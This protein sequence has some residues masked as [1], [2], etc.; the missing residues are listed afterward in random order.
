MSEVF[1]LSNAHLEIEERK[2]Y[3][4]ARVRGLLATAA[5]VGRTTTL[6]RDALNKMPERRLLIDAQQLDLPLPDP[7]C[8]AA[9]E[10]I[11]A[12]DYSMLACTLPHE[13]GDLT[14]TRM[15]MTGLSSGL[16]LRAFSNILDAHR[17]LDLRPSGIHRRPSSMLPI[18]TDPHQSSFA[19]SSSSSAQF[20][21][22]RPGLPLK[23][24]PSEPP[25]R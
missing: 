24:R 3:L 4:F 14:V 13:P 8:H 15:N 11:H 23:K 5:E 21:A 16:P 25:S 22:V 17:W 7:A 12:K 20:P 9:W 6:V 1:R 2:G 18:P 19:A 10:F